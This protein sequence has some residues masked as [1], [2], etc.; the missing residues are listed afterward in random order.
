[1][2]DSNNITYIGIGGFAIFGSVL[3]VSAIIKVR[4]I[5]EEH[6]RPAIKR[7]LGGIW[8]LIPVVVGTVLSAQSAFNKNHGLVLLF[9]CCVLGVIFIQQIVSWTRDQ[10]IFE[11][12]IYFKG[13]WYNWSEIKFIEE[14]R[15]YNA[16]K[17]VEV[18]LES[19][20]GGGS[21]KMKRWF[22]EDDFDMFLRL[23]RYQYYIEREMIEYK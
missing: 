21:F 7:S 19:R 4:G 13:K 18:T 11:D 16:F 8:E 9:M 22:S 23:S 15:T 17:K 12:G 3:M 6:G 2:I 10:L 14:K 5:Y 1:M 20:E